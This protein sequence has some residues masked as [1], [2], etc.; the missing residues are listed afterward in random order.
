MIHLFK[1]PITIK[2]GE[3]A[4]IT[5]RFKLDRDTGEITIESLDFEITKTDA[6]EPP[7]AEVVGSTVVGRIP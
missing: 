3:S 6:S 5:P 1:E 7:R 2:S 4:T